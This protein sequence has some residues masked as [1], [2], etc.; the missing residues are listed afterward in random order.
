MRR[1]LVPVVALLLTAC[2]TVA[3]VPAFSDEQVA[4]LQ[5]NGFEKVGDNWELGLS[6]RLLFPT[7]QSRLGE[8]QARNIERLSQALKS[9][10]VHGARVVGHADS[11]GSEAYNDQLSKD[12]AEA[13]RQAM[14]RSGM[15][16]DAVKAEGLGARQPIASNATADGR[17]ENRRVVVIV[18]SFNVS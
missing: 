3:P 14:I 17:Q 7:D 2:Q 13:V 6:D 11:T 12:R 4:V 9:V 1:W 18:T 10:G 8:E 15:D 5:E 16:A